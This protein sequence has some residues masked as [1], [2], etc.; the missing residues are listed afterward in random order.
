MRV[1]RKGRDVRSTTFLR[2]PLNVISPGFIQ[3]MET[4]EIIWWLGPAPA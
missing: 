1:R 4:F 2:T 3:E